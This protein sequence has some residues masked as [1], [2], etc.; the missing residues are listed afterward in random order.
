VVGT[1][2]AQIGVLL[3]KDTAQSG[4]TDEKFKVGDEWEYRARKSEEKIYSHNS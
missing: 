3:Q 1:L 2:G 4:A